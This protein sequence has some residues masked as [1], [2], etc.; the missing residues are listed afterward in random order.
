MQKQNTKK[1]YSP[2]TKKFVA[3]KNLTNINRAKNISINESDLSK[4]QNGMQ[5]NTQ[6]LVRGKF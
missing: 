4:I 2:T 1:K 6:G 5:V 3:P